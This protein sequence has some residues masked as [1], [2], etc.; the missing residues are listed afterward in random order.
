[1]QPGPSGRGAG[2]RER[3]F[4]WRLAVCLERRRAVVLPTLT[5]AVSHV[6]RLRTPTTVPSSMRPTLTSLSME[7]AVSSVSMPMILDL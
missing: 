7:P 2:V 1:M 4:G 6:C 3:A 5:L